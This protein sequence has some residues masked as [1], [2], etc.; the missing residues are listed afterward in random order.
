MYMG[1]FNQNIIEA[2]IKQKKYA[3]IKYVAVVCSFADCWSS[4]SLLTVSSFLC[5]VLYECNKIAFQKK[6]W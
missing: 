2:D 5:P 6:V 4:L 1:K 3:D